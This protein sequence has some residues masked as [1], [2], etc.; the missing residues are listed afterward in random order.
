MAVTSRMIS[1]SREKKYFVFSVENY[2]NLLAGFVMKM[3][4]IKL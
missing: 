1:F 2:F 4:L 3:F